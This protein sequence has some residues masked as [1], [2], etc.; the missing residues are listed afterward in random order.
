MRQFDVYR[1][2]VLIGRIS[3]DSLEPGGLFVPSPEYVEIKHLFQCEDHYSNLALSADITKEQ[4]TRY[5]ELADSYLG[6]IL[7]PGIVMREVGSSLSFDVLGL[8][9]FGDRAVWR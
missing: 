4:K 6:E 3:L 8:S 5:Q 9:I 7:A 2:G 1:G